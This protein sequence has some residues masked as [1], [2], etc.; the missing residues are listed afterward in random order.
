MA[1]AMPTN[2]AQTPTITTTVKVESK[3][4]GAGTDG[5]GVGWT[6][7]VAVGGGNVGVGGTTVGV[8]EGV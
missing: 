5:R 7:G 1:T 4:T 6:V 2:T 8:A 3:R